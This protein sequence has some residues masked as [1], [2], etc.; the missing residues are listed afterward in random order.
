[1]EENK[2]RSAKVLNIAQSEHF[3][4]YETLADYAEQGWLQQDRV[5]SRRPKFNSWFLL[6]IAINFVAW[7][8]FGWGIWWL[9]IEGP[10]HVA[11]WV[12]WIRA[13]VTAA[14]L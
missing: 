5:A 10:A 6:G 11:G 8:A 2:V 9:A 13:V 7:F 1:M 3:A 14:F 12:H 4:D